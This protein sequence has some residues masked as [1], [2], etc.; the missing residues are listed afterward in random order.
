G[1]GEEMINQL[2][3]AGLVRGIPD[4]YHLTLEQLVEL[5]RVGEKS[6]QNLLDG[7]TASKTRGLARLLAG[8]AIPHVGDAV[9][10]LLAME[11][12]SIDPL[13]EASEERL[14]AVEGIGPIMAHDIHEFFQNEAERKTIDELR[15]AGVK[16]TEDVAPKP[17]GG[18][19]LSG[20][21]F[22]VTGTLQNYKRDEIEALIR[23]LGGKVA[24]SVSKKTDYLVAG[25]EPG[26][27]LEKAKTLRVAIIS[28]E[29]FDKM[30][31]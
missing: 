20:K 16:M 5:E 30:I 26:S 15:A 23:K 1:L 12:G 3:D 7:I 27:K 9:A 8:L 28:E 31:G 11:F 22:V 13:L 10:R 6:G 18:P 29:D 25:A 24:G 19:D 4:L 2:V 17:K 14:N 21:T